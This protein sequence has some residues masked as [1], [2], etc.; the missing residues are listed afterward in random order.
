[1]TSRDVMELFDTVGT[2]ARVLIADAPA[3]TLQSWGQNQ[4]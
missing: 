2:G 1:M 3:T 4:P